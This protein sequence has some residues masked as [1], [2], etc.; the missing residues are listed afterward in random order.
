LPSIGDL[1]RSLCGS[2]LVRRAKEIRSPQYFGRRFDLYAARGDCAV[3][4]IHQVHYTSSTTLF[5]ILSAKGCTTEGVRAW[6]LPGHASEWGRL[7]VLALRG[8]AFAHLLD[9]GLFRLDGIGGE[10]RDEPLHAWLGKRSF[11]IF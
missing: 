11:P 3:V 5:G 10:L 1:E 9:S 2:V 7:P 8:P 6:I 4:D